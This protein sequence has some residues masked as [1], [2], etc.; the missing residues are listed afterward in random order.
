MY[1]LICM[2]GFE[3]SLGYSEECFGV[4]I[5][6]PSLQELYWAIFTQRLRMGT[7]QVNVY[8]YIDK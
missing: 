5:W 3:V 4:Y 2:F 8:I 1:L 6:R 7:V